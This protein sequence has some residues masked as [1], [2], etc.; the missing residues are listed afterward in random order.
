MTQSVSV[1]IPTWNSASC[2]LACLR[3]LVG[4]SIAEI[5]VV[6]NGST[7]DTATL[8][9]DFDSRITLISLDTNEGFATAANLGIRATTGNFVL[10]LN[11]DA[12]LEPGYVHALT[13]TLRAYPNA[14]SAVGKLLKPHV[15]PAHI[16]SAGIVLNRYALRPLDRGHG[17]VDAGQ[18]DTPGTVFG[19]SAA[20]ALYRRAALDGLNEEPFDTSLFAY[21]EDVD[22]AWR[23]A[24]AGWSHRYAPSAVAFHTRRGPDTKPERIRARAFANRYIVWAKNESM[25][26]FAGY[27]PVALSW[28]AF[29]LAKRALQQPA[30]LSEVPS[31]LVRALAIVRGR[32]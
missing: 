6:D 29:R 24:R 3:S 30:L 15:H 10:L 13:L 7:D 11:D 27:A 8:V 20:A 5:V 17:D 16:D 21:Y 19:V 1:V 31:S 28:E 2:I 22:L 32:L 26:R 25:L 4:Q 18:Y 14:A 12:T 23:L 9:R